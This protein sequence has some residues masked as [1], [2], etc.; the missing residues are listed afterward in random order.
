MAEHRAEEL[1]RSNAALEQL[2]YVVAHD[3]RQPLRTIKSYTQK[4]AE[5]CRG[6]LDPQ[7]DDYLART[8]NAADRMRVLIDDLLA[9]SR[10][11]TQGKEPAPVGC[12]AALTA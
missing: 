3:L 6:Q 1:A 10:V 9:Y 7:A 5:R 4:L 2:G 8:V 11:R 12:T